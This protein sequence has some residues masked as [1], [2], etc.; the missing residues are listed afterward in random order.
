MEIDGIG[1]FYCGGRGTMDWR[2]CGVDGDIKTVVSVVE[3]YP[4]AVITRV[5]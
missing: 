2:S 5:R 3:V 1:Y 4:E